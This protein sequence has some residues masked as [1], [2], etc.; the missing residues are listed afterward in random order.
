MYAHPGKKLLFMGG[1][2][3]QWREWNHNQS[4]D[5]HLND[6][7]EHDGLKR[8]VIH[9]NY[10]YRTEPA[11]YEQDDSYAGFEWIDFHDSDNSVVAF[12][13]KASNG[14]I[15]AFVVNA[16]PVPREAYRI[17]VTGE[18]FYQE[19][20]NTDAQTYGGANFG[21]CGGLHAEPI[22]W[23]GKSHSLL[24]RL[25]PLGLVGLKRIA[26]EKESKKTEIKSLPPAAV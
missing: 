11:L 7:P 8:L 23:Q 20:L 12:M 17:G 16:T 21:N 25:P 26:P 22:P 18:G 13:R 19:V 15:I 24:L 5:W 4:L 9:L 1:E 10:L 14:D 6:W 2:F 3:G